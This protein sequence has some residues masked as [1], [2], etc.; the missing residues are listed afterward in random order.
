M[1][2]E[3]QLEIYCVPISNNTYVVP[4]FFVLLT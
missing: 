2:G 1:A 3:L 4:P